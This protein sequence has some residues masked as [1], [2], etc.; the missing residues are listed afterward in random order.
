MLDLSLEKMPIKRY[1]HYGL[2][3][4]YVDN[5]YQINKIEKA[6]NV[7]NILVSIFQDRIEYYSSL[8]NYGISHQFDDIEGTLL[9]YNNVV[10]TADKYD[11]EFADKL[12]K[13]YVASISLLEGVIE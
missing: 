10:A 9:M 1:G 12:K 2:V 4:G 7:A 3:L 6:R 8:D 13:G 11:K 5:Y